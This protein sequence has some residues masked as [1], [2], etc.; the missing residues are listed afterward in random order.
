[1]NEGH[2]SEAIGNIL[3]S[4][5]EVVEN[6][7]EEDDLGDELFC[8]VDNILPIQKLRKDYKKVLEENAEKDEVI[9]KIKRK[10]N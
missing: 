9:A 8:P 3:E 5:T 4:M 7:R 2:E 10:K 1:M 6:I